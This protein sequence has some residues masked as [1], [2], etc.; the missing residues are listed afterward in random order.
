MLN[1]LKTLK[2][3]QKNKKKKRRKNEKIIGYHVGRTPFSYFFSS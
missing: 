2:Q 1:E 3:K